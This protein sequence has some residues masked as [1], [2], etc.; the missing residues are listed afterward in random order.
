VLTYFNGSLQVNHVST[1]LLALLLYPVMAK[2]AEQHAGVKPRTVVVTSDMHH[3]V[4]IP[5]EVLSKQDNLIAYMSKEENCPPEYAATGSYSQSFKAIN[6]AVT[7]AACSIGSSWID[8]P[9]LSV[10]ALLCSA[11]HI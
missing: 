6:F 4:V 2:T 3:Y 5:Q 11:F 1:F 9:S 7:D 8:T 10:R